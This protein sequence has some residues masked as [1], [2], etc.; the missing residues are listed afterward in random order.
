MNGASG[1]FNLPA[2]TTNY[3]AAIVC[4]GFFEYI[5]LLTVSDTKTP[6]IACPGPGTSVAA[7]AYDVSAIPGAQK[8][9]VYIGSSASFQ[10]T[11]TGTA[12]FT[13]APAGMQDVGVVGFGAAGTDADAVKF[14]RGVSVPGPIGPVV[15]QAADATSTA[16][17]VL[18]GIPNG[19]NSQV[20]VNYV[21]A[22][23]A[24]LSIKQAGGT[25]TYPTVAAADS[26]P[27][28][29]YQIQS[30]ASSNG[31]LINQVGAYQ[32][33]ASP[34]SVTLNL[35]TP[36]TYTGPAPARY[37]TYTP[38]A[39]TFDLAGTTAYQFGA[40]TPFGPAI[41]VGT[42]AAYLATVGNTLQ[43]PNLSSLVAFASITPPASG[44]AEDWSLEESVTSGATN[45]YLFQPPFPVNT[46][47]LT[48]YASGQYTVP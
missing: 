1:T 5:V 6:S 18:N 33:F 17:I 13:T 36:L 24:A 31:A 10:N 35:P 46:T 14:Q 15:A 48:V 4:N 20:N 22:G 40:I 2:G 38:P 29:Q 37:P 41:Y 28:D 16:A 34:Q 3:G 30:Y 21:T 45:N 9:N 25:S 44:S 32:T 8:A 42:S 47:A 11:A 39:Y 7:V 23:G 19:Y 12:N 27:G 43:I 26:L